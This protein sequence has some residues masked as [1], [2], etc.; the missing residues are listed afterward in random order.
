MYGQ[1]TDDSHRP[2]AQKNATA[3]EVSIDLDK[4]NRE[5]FK[6]GKLRDSIICN[7]CGK[8]RCIFSAKKLDMVQVKL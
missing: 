5:V 4:R 8:P 3:D 7:E 1:E 2:S 6:A